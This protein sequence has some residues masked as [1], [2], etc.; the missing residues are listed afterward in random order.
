MDRY[1]RS[2]WTMTWQ[3]N[4]RVGPDLDLHMKLALSNVGAVLIA[5][6]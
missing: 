5:I 2:V 6:Q 4:A 3:I 1:G